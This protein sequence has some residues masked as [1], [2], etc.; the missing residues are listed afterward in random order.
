VFRI[1]HSAN[2]GA[3]NNPIW[4]LQSNRRYGVAND[5]GGDQR[6]DQRG[7]AAATPAQRAGFETDEG[8]GLAFR[9]YRDPRVT[10]AFRGAAFLGGV[11]LHVDTRYVDQ[12]SDVPLASGVEARL[13]EAEALLQAGD[14]AG[15]LTKLNNLRDSASVL[16]P[17]LFPAI[18][19][20][21]KTEFPQTLARLTDPGSRDARVDMLFR[22]RALWM[23]LTGHRLGD[24]RRLVRQYGRPQSTVF[25]TGSFAYVRAGA[26][27][28]NDV[29]F[30]IPFT[31]V[32]NTQFNPA[33]CDPD[34]A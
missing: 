29:A 7:D 22:E 34:Q 21:T 4:A 25:P 16:I 3:Q 26:V 19:D 24:L 33:A 27:Y 17:I 28:G 23:F 18:Q 6:P 30:P 14:N 12:N 31:E 1:E 2:T 9:A 11:N 10:W 15:F 32:N 13:I 8:E 20:A 5:E